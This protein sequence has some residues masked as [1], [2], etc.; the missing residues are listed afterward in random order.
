LGPAPPVSICLTTYN[1]ASVLPGTIESLLAQSFPDF[2]LIIQ[3]DCSPDDTEAICRDYQGR[4]RRIKYCRNMENLRMPGNL[5]AAIRRAE[6]T[7]IAN[8]HD[9][10]TYRPDLIGKWKRALDEVPGA[11]FAFNEYEWVSEDGKRTIHRMQ[12][13][14]R[15]DGKKVALHF[16]ATFS[17]CVWGTVMARRTAYEKEGLFN[18]A[19]G[20]ISDVDMWLRLAHGRD[21][22]YVPE[23]LITL[24]PREPDHPYAFVNWRT[25]FWTLGMYVEHLRRYESILPKEVARFAK[26]YPG[27]RR[28]LFMRDM[29]I[30]IKHMRWDRVREGLAI[31]RDADDLFLKTLGSCFGDRA[32]LPDWY[33]RNA[34]S[35]CSIR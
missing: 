7:Y 3:D 35:V 6:G 9:G 19:Y 28:R 30:C 32:H 18:P 29:A 27:R 16:F 13:G 20:F 25:H 8:V 24:T 21:V 15:M 23:P 12:E 5:N 17:S 26:E 22:A 1:R 34:W 2:E 31:L 33:D 14:G 11:A 10:D 4:D